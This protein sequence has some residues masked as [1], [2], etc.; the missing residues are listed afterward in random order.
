M[1]FEPGNGL[2]FDFV[3]AHLA[4]LLSRAEQMPI[5]GFFFRVGAAVAVQ[6]D[7]DFRFAAGFDDGSDEYAIVPDDGASMAEPGN[8]RLPAHILA[9]CHIPRERRRVR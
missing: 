7:F 1:T 8:G 4:G 6:S 3:P 5:V 9:R 2:V